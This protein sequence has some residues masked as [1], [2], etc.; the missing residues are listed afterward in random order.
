[1]QP[2]RF[3]ADR[4]VHLGSSRQAQI[5]I[6]PAVGGLFSFL[7]GRISD[8]FLGLVLLSLSLFFVLFYTGRLTP[9]LSNALPRLEAINLPI[10]TLTSQSQGSREL[11][12]QGVT[13]ATRNAPLP[14]NAQISQ[15][16]EV[17]ATSYDRNCR[18][19]NDVTAI[20]MKAG[21]GVVA[22]DPKIIPL[23]SKLYIPGY[24]LAVAGDTGGKV[25]GN[26]IDLG[27]ENVKTGWWSARFVEI[28]VL[29]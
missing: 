10:N 18:G 1:M 13:S 7:F 5:S 21:Y 6:L 16:L 14:Q 26:R 29:K 20:G 17:F 2:E 22:V 3:K 15:K 4:Q 28:Y 8:R 25:K 12:E 24:G 27:F 23:G 9:L 19:C 11:S